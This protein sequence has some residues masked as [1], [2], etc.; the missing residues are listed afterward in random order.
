MPDYRLVIAVQEAK[1]YATYVA[2]KL[3]VVCV[4]GRTEEFSKVLNVCIHE[5]DVVQNVPHKNL[6]VEALVVIRSN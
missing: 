5:A 3:L 6:E 2:S 1:N 4:C